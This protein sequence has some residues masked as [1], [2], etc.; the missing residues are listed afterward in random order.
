MK[1]SFYPKL[2]FDSIR[3]NKIMYLP[4]IL[5]CIGM[6]MMHNIICTLCED[7]S[8]YTISG[9]NT[10]QSMM[11]FGKWVIAIF[12]CIFLF[13]TNS[14][15]IRRRKKEFGLYNI[16]GM[17]KKNIALVQLWEVMITAAISIG[18]GIFLGIVLSKAAGLGML[19]MLGAEINYRFEIFPEAIINT[20]EVFGAVF[21]LLFLSSLMQLRFSSASA[22]IKSEN[23]GEKPPKGNILFGAAGVILLCFA[24]YQAV[25]I[26]NPVQAL[27]HFFI[28]VLMVIVATYLIMIAGSVLFCR[29]LQKNKKYYYRSDHFVSVSSMVYRMKRNGAGLAS[30]CI[31]ATMVLVTIVTT[32]CL[33]FGSED[34]LNTV[35]PREINIEFNSESIT[36]ISEDKI[37]SLE[38]E[39]LEIAEKAGAKT[40]N[41][42]EKR[43]VSVTG[44]VDGKTVEVNSSAA[45]LNDTSIY[46]ELTIF[47]VIAL[48]D[49]NRITGK[50]ETLKNGE[51]M[52]YSAKKYDYDTISFNGGKTFQV[53][54]VLDKFDEYATDPADIVP[55]M[56]LIVPNVKDAVS[57]L[58]QLTDQNEQ[59]L[60][61][62]N[63]EYFFDTGLD[64]E[65]QISLAKQYNDELKLINVSHDNEKFVYVNCVSKVKEKNSLLANYAG[66]FYL[67]I[68]L[69][70]VFLFA[71]VLI[72]YYKQISEGYEDQARF[73]IMQKVGMTKKEIRRSINSQLLTVFFLPL[74]FAGCHLC[75]AFPFVKKLL[76]L[77][78]LTNNTLLILTT[79]ISF[80]AFALIYVIVYKITSNAY[81]HIVSE[82][83]EK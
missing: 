37:D 70:V 23:V 46:S 76:L 35:Y 3:K 66:M 67:G 20:L 69:S 74:F 72:I 12:A 4:Y 19:N 32:A 81:Y 60:L 83:K 22:L 59:T 39:I 27:M 40:K 42:V 1:K 2:A 5:T 33:Y 16:L 43:Y 34:S 21:V 73:A 26:K 30:I 28:A 50:N 57:G 24:Y 56:T 53:K 78:D 9:G 25:T 17:G 18:A 65:S 68:S 58:D 14:F 79:A 80:L 54:K 15:I 7:Q 44:I 63:F 64:E 71:A 62:Y 41:V 77:F 29:L 75:F 38:K 61:H 52:I 11:G 55:V 48:D 13:Y 47:S 10:I 49:Y 8:L 82:A 31:L 45:K 36:A 51:V 6:V